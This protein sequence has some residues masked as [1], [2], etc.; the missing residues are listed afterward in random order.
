MTPLLLRLTRIDVKHV[1]ART[2]HTAA[3]VVA[4]LASPGLHAATYY[5]DSNDSTA[6]FGTAQGT[7][8]APTTNNATQGWTS[9][10][11]GTTNTSTSDALNFG[12]STNQLGTGTITVSG[13]VSAN[14]ITIVG[15]SSNITL[16]GGNIT[17]GASSAI[18]VT[19]SANTSAITETISSNITLGASPTWTINNGGTVGTAGLNVSGNVLGGANGLT[20]S[21]NGTLTLSGA[22][23][24]WNGTTSVSAG[25][26][27]LS[28]SLTS[29][30]SIAVN[31]AANPVLNITGNLTQTLSGNNR[32][33][34]IAGSSNSYGTVN[35]SGSGILNI[36]GGML[37]SEDSGGN[38]VFNQSGGTVNTN[39]IV[40]LGG[41]TSSLSVSGGNFNMGSNQMMLGSGN[42]AK[43]NSTLSVSGT[44]MISLGLL[45]VGAYSRNAT[46]ITINLGDG[47]VG[48]NL[49]ITNMAYGALLTSGIATFNF[50]GGTLSTNGNFG[51]VTQ[52]S[53][54][55]KAGG[56][57][58]N[59]L[60]ATTPMAPAAA[61]RKTAPARS[62]SLALETT[63]PARPR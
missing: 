49:S 23:N 62:H 24:S 57:T 6:G 10:M 38:G 18:T 35:V 4:L 39:G 47:T 22:A 33:F 1:V 50:N 53:T 17:L 12:T 48:G 58:F 16:S 60:G 9:P 59:V 43:S 37:I 15:S 8:A 20:K 19:N 54:I 63:T 52:A 3:L 34:V 46:A 45:N 26:L 56:A 5:W 36:G 30:G 42:P 21:G 13:N 51:V 7:W 14:T 32:N 29:N 31:G 44:G 28:G 55:V 25:T 27:T 40:W 61:S 11:S 2:F 41:Q